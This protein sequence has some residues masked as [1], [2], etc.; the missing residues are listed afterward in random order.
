MLIAEKYVALGGPSGSLG[1]PVG[2]ET[3]AP[4]GYGRFARYVNGSIYW[5]PA[6]GAHALRGAVDS[7]YRAGTTAATLGYPITDDGPHRGDG[8]TYAVFQHGALHAGGGPPRIVAARRGSIHAHAIPVV[9]AG[10]TGIHLQWMGP[11]SWTYSA[12]GYWV[13][14]RPASQIPDTLKQCVELTEPG[15]IAARTTGDAAVA[16]GAVLVRHGVWPYSTPPAAP[17]PCDVIA[18]ELAAVQDGVKVTLVGTGVDGF[19]FALRGGKVVAGPIHASQGELR[20]IAIDTVVAYGRNVK[21]VTWCAREAA[22]VAADEASWDHVPY[23]VEGLQLPLKTFDPTIDEYGVGAARVPPG[24]ITS[25]DFFQLANPLRASLPAVAGPPPIDQI[26]LWRDGSVEGGATE[27]AA[28]LDPLRMVLLHPTWRRVLGMAIFDQAGLTVGARYQYRITGV[29][30]VEDLEDAIYSF[31]T[32][33]SSTQV[34]VCFSLGVLRVRLPE[35]STIVRVPTGPGPVPC[36]R[37]LALRPWLGAFAWFGDLSDPLA[38]ASIAL[39]LPAPTSS[40]VVEVA[41]ASG[42]QY[43]GYAGGTAVAP[44]Q[45]LPAAV[46]RLTLAAPIDQLRLYGEGVLLGVRVPSAARGLVPVSVTLQPVTLADTPVP[47]PPAPA[48]IANLQVPAPPPSTNPVPAE[49]VPP[50]HLLGFEVRWT[51]PAVG[52]AWPPDDPAARPLASTMFQL[53]H[54]EGTGAWIDVLDGDNW[55]AGSR[56]GAPPEPVRPG[57]DLLR[58]YPEQRPPEP[59]AYLTWRDTFSPDLPGHPPRRPRPAPGTS[60]SYRIRSVDTI[61]RPSAT[62]TTTAALTLQKRVPP[63]LPAAWDNTR[64]YP[65]GSNVPVPLTPRPTGVFAKVLQPGTSD[66]A[67]ELASATDLTP[68]ER[69]ALTAMSGNAIVL[70]WGWHTDQ[71]DQDPFAREFRLYVTPPLDVATGQL[72]SYTARPTGWRLQLVL[73]R[74]IEA[75]AATGLYLQAGYAF[76]VVGHPAGT[77]VAVDVDVAARADGSRPAPVVGS[78]RLPI[79]YAPTMGRPSRWRDRVAV[80]PITAATQYHHIFYDVLALTPAHPRDR[81]WVGVSAADLESYVPDQRTVPPTRTGNE[82]AIVTVSCDGRLDRRPV[83]AHVPPLA[84]VPVVIAPE[85]AGRPVAL[86]LDL[87]AWLPGGLFA[88]DDSMMPERVSAGD[89]IGAYRV[90]GAELRAWTVARRPGEPADVALAAFGG[91]AALDRDAIIAAFAGSNIEDVDG[92]YLVWLAARHPNADRLFQPAVERAVSSTSFRE[93]LPATGG[94]WLYRARKANASGQLSEGAAYPQVIVRVPS[95][96]PGPA[97][98][99]ERITLGETDVTLRLRA[100]RTGLT[101]LLVFTR[102]LVGAPATQAGDVLRIPNRP[103]LAPARLEQMVLLRTSDGLLSPTVKSLSDPDV[104]TSSDGVCHADLRFTGPAGQVLQVWACT[105]TRDLVPSRVA[106][107]FRLTMPYAGGS[108]G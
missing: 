36:R 2:S 50:R 68:A 75:N 4:D 37:G 99:Q 94:R 52:D 25:G 76:H 16:L 67:D 73:D 57:C 10:A 19:L 22:D 58:I 48:T 56:S 89:V 79:R 55:I 13:Q 97:P 46:A 17:P 33:P 26:A 74:A 39:D 84:D 103:D 21:S 6:T 108:H 70:R 91:L 40:I 98:E 87:A 18:L 31:H 85:P 35:P 45:P 100:P 5:T 29:F 78:I 28:A 86:D 47:P 107:P 105:L 23:L 59:A 101:H 53:Q 93:S 80:V 34:P 71:R 49:V 69:A 1:A 9:G 51:P 82:S 38:G 43:A 106:G 102:P 104:T 66:L 12:A 88:A 90:E 41:S 32:V 65:P 60:H 24:A 42:I 27:E 92:K 61:G 77:A 72:A 64:E 44:K 30:P 96:M 3:P 8:T 14:R 81:M 62:W 20:A 63:P 83:V 11:V 54:R 95:P 7:A 15:L